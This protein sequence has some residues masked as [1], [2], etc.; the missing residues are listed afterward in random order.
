MRP[1]RDASGFG[2]AVLLAPVAAHAQAVPADIGAGTLPQDLSVSV[3]FQ[4]ADFV[5]QAVLVGL[6]AA[7]VVTWTILLAKG[8]GFLVEQRSLRRS[9]GEVETITKARITALN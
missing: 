9:L 6:L 4:H 5:V 7:S 1:W 3:M 8:A 2:L